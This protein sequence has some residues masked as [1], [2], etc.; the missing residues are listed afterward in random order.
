MHKYC[1]FNKI[2]FHKIDWWFK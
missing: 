1:C 2:Y